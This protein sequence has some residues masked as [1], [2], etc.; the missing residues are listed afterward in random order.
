MQGRMVP[1]W[2][3]I[4]GVG[5]LGGVAL[6]Q[7]VSKLYVNG[8]LASSDVRLINGVAYVPV[9]DIAAA[10]GWQVEKR[11]D[12]VNLLPSGGANQLAGKFTGK[13]GERVFT[14]Q[15]GLTVTSVEEN[16]KYEGKYSNLY[17]QGEATGNDKVIVV[18]CRVTNGMTTKQ[19]LVFDNWDYNNKVVSNTALADMQGRSYPPHRW[20]IK[21]TESAPNG[22]TL[23]P[24]A[25][26]D[27]RLSS[28]PRRTRPRKTWCTRSCAMTSG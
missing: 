28:K 20:D 1:S 23:L 17:G 16:Q 3:L 10:Q 19:N 24:G 7:G 27:S 15:Y 8:K 11:A 14:G 4:A 22:V 25:S 26:V 6:A 2:V 18:N 13:I 21:A 5:A 12:G 9:K